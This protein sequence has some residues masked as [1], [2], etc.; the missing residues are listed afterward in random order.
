MI[1]RPVLR[2]ILD[3]IFI[4]KRKFFSLIF[5]TKKTA[6]LLS[7]HFI[8]YVT[9]LVTEKYWL[10]D[11]VPVLKKHPPVLLLV[12]LDL[13]GDFIIWL[14]SAKKYREL[15]PNHKIVL[16][17]NSSCTAL[18]RN[19]PFW[20]E[21][22]SIDVDRL[23]SSAM[24]R[25]QVLWKLRV[26]GFNI[27]I[28][29]TY[30]REVIG[31]IVVRAT[32]APQRIGY[33]GDLN[34]ISEANKEATDCWYTQLI[35]NP[36]A[37]ISELNINAH[38]LHELGD[39]NYRSAIFELPSQ[40]RLSGKLKLEHHY[41][42]VAPGASWY[43]KQ[44]PA[45]NFIDL[46]SK[47]HIDFKLSIVLCG[48]PKEIELCKKIE[49]DIS[50]DWIINLAGQTT[51]I[52]LVELI[53]GASLL[54]GNDSAP[55][56]MAA[57]TGTKSVCIL[58]GGHFNRFLPY[59]PQSFSA[60]SEPIIVAHPMECYGCRWKCIYNPDQD[61]AVPCVNQVQ[62]SAVYHACGQALILQKS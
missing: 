44:W 54:I 61:Q 24:Y 32:H 57:V 33:Q 13:I 25:M 19:L 49:A 37:A 34:N 40:G 3:F 29:P 35:T 7:L 30:S 22:A 6:Q 23:R 43:P 27:A 16:A 26:R 38:F 31:D 62:V 36:V 20:D 10:I 28:Q 18:A 14:D 50:Q 12:R 4:F 1:Q 21:V 2:K 60:G 8:T 41:I 48:G 17:V 58:G 45:V 42:V 52:E 5:L 9:Q 15:Y 53:R 59:S 56:H 46:I 51:L 47:L 39:P 55:I 11:Y